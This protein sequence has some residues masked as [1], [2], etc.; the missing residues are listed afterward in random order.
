MKNMRHQKWST[1]VTV[2]S[3][4]RGNEGIKVIMLVQNLPMFMM[5]LHNLLR[6]C[7]DALAVTDSS[8]QCMEAVC[9]RWRTP[10]QPLPTCVMYLTYVC[11]LLVSS[12]LPYPA[13]APHQ[14]THCH[15]V[16]QHQ[17][18]TFIENF[19]NYLRNIHPFLFNYVNTF[20]T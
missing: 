12:V 18:Q 13:P 10:M 17:E 7:T 19:F 9:A 4:S 5:S 16:T 15:H 14:H 3:R 6:S 11:P 2:F 8:Y 20:L 1:T